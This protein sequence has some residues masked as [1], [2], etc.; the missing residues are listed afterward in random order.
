[1]RCFEP[2]CFVNTVLDNGLTVNKIFGCR[3]EVTSCCHLRHA[4]A[5]IL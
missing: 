1:M 5:V 4:V 2:S 3:S